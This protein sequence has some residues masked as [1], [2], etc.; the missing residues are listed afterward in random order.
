MS[1]ECYL[2]ACPHHP[3]DEPICPR[4]ECAFKDVPMEFELWLETYGARIKSRW[5]E[6][7]CDF[8]L[9]QEQERQ[10]EKYLE[11]FEQGQGVKCTLP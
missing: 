11:E 9:E 2:S 6:A 4:T 1:I 5:L 7:N 8:N 10:F 3:G